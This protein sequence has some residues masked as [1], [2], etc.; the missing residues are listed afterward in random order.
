[1]PVLASRLLFN[2]SSSPGWFFD[3]P[4]V[5]EMEKYG[6]TGNQERDNV[7]RYWLELV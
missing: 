3:R 6:G 5:L 1:M 4:H 7:G 2:G